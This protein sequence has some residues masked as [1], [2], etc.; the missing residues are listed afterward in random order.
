MASRDF[1]DDAAQ[2]WTL[3][4]S[5]YFDPQVFAREREEIFHKSWWYVGAVA[6]VSGPGDYLTA[7]VVDQDVVVVRG[8]DG[9][10]RGFFNTCRHRAHRLLDGTG[11]CRRIVCPYHGWTYETD[12]RF[13]TGRGIAGIANFDRDAA[14]LVPVRVETMLGLVF[15]NL[16]PETLSL[17]ATASG[18]L[19]D[20]RR[21]C[22]DLDTL[23]LAKS[24]E[25]KSAANWKVLVDNDLES[26]HVKTA[27]SA[28][29]DLLDY[30]SFRVWEY[31]YATCHAME[32]T[33]AQN[34]AYTVVD[35][36]AVK[37]AIY[38][39]LWPNTAFFIAPG[40]RNLGVFQMIPTSPESSIQKWDF[41]FEDTD[42]VEAEREYLAYTL[43]ILIPEDSRLYENVQR[44]VRS[45]SYQ[46]GRFVINYD[47]PELS[48]HHVHKFQK[49]V[50][51]AVL[52]LAS[53]NG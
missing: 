14:G 35:N 40:R 31:D 37:T 33:T 18:M 9:G 13:V 4:S 22:P 29:T 15:V 8:R 41:Y 2:S 11:S 32:N 6:A 5:W 19:A 12:G 51:E 34:A 16:D 24:H 48:E 42:L 46:A 39:W 49:M 10:L 28:L 17:A 52:P 30:S 53:G 1:Q 44:G 27:H 45:K 47:Q 38:T 25:V 21:H 50:R 43:D 3:P 36:A 20:M 26:Y 7:T 23:V